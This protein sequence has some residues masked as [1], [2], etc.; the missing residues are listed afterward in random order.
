MHEMHTVNETF[1]I[2]LKELTVTSAVLEIRDVPKKVTFTP[3][4]YTNF[5]YLFFSNK[6]RSMNLWER[7]ILLYLFF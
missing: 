6:K 7:I 3:C 2:L 4:V 1:H 5:S